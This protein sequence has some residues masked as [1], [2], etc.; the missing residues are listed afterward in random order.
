[1]NAARRCA[2]LTMTDTAGWSI[3]AELAIPH[4]RA[5][6]WTVAS[7]PWRAA[8]ID[9]R[10]W[11]AVYIGTPWDYPEDPQAFLR[12]LEAIEV[13]GVT[14]LNPLELVR[15]NIDKTYL[16]DL[17]ARG[18]AI[19]P[20][21]FRERLQAT[22]LPALRRELGAEH[23]VVKPAISTNASDTYPLRGD[24]DASLATVLDASF[25]NRAC[26]VQP[27]IDAIRDDGEYSL[28]FI[29]GELSH[30]IRKIPAQ[31]DFRVQEEHGAEIRACES[32]AGLAQT[33]RDVLALVEPEP[34][35][36][37][38]DFVQGSS[39][40]FL[41]MELELIEPSLYLRMDQAAP[42]RFAQAFDSRVRAAR[43]DGV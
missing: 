2:F 42:A 14:L 24:P 11:D 34:L 32:P 9:W 15:W 31:G 25:G 37:R 16:R 28:F 21:V 20:T 38:A 6:N 43:Q 19:V 18:A 17:E 33:A 35:Y 26:L 3:D 30:T 7:V 29:G 5:L 10:A 1:M 22:D 13:A 8:R 27:F 39:G 36:A 12:V 41:L 40:R 4:L 23:L